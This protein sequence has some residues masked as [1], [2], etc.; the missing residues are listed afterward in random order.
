METGFDYELKAYEALGEGKVDEAQ[1][2]ATL[3]QAR[4]TRELKEVTEQTK[5][6]LSEWKKLAAG[7]P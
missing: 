7:L 3:H 6:L 2:W 4:M 1:V 5:E